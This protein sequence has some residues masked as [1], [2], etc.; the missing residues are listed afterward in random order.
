QDLRA[1]R[2]TV[3]HGEQSGTWPMH[4]RDE[5]TGYPVSLDTYPNMTIL[6]GSDNW[7]NFPAC[8]GNCSSPYIP[9]N[10]HHP[11]LAYVPYL[12]TGDYY[13][14]EELQFWANWIMF[15]GPQNRH[16]GA[17]GLVSWDQT[18]GQAWGLRTLGHAAYATP[19]S[20]PM[21]S[22]FVGKL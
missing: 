21:K 13:F 14:L 22:Y 18:R 8:G 12:I 6:G 9:E 17:L 5:A 15:Y 3:G 20:H 16:G 19:D 4:Y 1:K 10:A 11:S 2:V 7:G